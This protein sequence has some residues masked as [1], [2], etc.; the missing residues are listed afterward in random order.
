MPFNGQ[1]GDRAVFLP[2]GAPCIPDR[3]VPY[4]RPAAERF[5]PGEMNTLY[6]VGATSPTGA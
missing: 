5:A 3:S 1:A 4:T 6:K 2:W